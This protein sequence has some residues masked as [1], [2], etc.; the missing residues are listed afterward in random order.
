M[1]YTPEPLPTYTFKNGAVA[2]VHRV[3]QMTIA[4]IAAGVEKRTPAVPIPTFTTDLGAG[5]TEQP[6]PTSKEYQAAVAERRGRI[7]MLTM[8]KLIDL[9]I[10]IEID[11]AALAHLKA[12][13]ER[14]DEP[15]SELSDKVAFVKHC[16]VTDGSELTK[17]SA[18]IRGDTE[19]A[20]E[21]AAAT[22][23][24]DVPGPTAEPL[25]PAVVGGALQ[26]GVRADTRGALARHIRRGDGEPAD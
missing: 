25:E 4:Q 26:P 10:D 12:G 18:L 15:L 21:A 1:P 23:S 8:D 3:G 19:E 14:I 11:Q 20:A 16:C 6:N 13:M 5:P 22:F 7:N 2:T 24:S 9:A 17:L